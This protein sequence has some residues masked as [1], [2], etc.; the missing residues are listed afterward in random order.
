MADE[1]KT[2]EELSKIREPNSLQQ[3]WDL[4]RLRLLY[5]SLL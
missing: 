3:K 2:V 1:I 4:A 5:I